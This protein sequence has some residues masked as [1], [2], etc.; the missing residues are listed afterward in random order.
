MLH[1]NLQRVTS[2]RGLKRWFAA[3]LFSS[4][5]LVPQC[6]S[7]PWEFTFP[8]CN[9]KLKVPLHKSKNKLFKYFFT[10][11]FLRSTRTYVQALYTDAAILVCI[12]GIFP[13]WSSL[14]LIQAWCSRTF[15]SFPTMWM[16]S[17]AED[18]VAA[19]CWETCLPSN[20]HHKASLPFLS[21]FFPFDQKS[22]FN[23]LF[24]SVNAKWFF[25]RILIINT[26][27]TMMN[28]SIWFIITP[29]IRHHSECKLPLNY[30]FLKPTG[31][32]TCGKE[33]PRQGSKN[34]FNC[35]GVNSPSPLS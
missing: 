33:C 14:L 1:N 8:L 24:S 31:V 6:T 30:T 19:H 23:H 7:L 9:L 17:N 10:T 3:W 35:W 26:L 4:L 20:L 15:F 11:N 12:W 25:F 32:L 34:D 21:L 18:T 27:R 22:C 29:E 5:L 16:P 2:S 13:V 28:D